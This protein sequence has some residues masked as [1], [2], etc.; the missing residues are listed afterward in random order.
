MLEHLFA[1]LPPP[2]LDGVTAESQEGVL[3]CHARL[4]PVAAEEEGEKNE[5][6][7]EEEEVVDVWVQ[8]RL[9]LVCVCEE[10]GG[11]SR[12]CKVTPLPRCDLHS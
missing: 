8:V 11:M 5:E 12:H 7:E 6:K 10:E 9:L 1:F 2:S 4:P 3:R